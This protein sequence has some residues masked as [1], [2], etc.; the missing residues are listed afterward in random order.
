[1][2][3]PLAKVVE[4]GDDLFPR[5]LV[6][7]VDVL[8][9]T[10]VDGQATESGSNLL[11]IDGGRELTRLFC[12]ARQFVE[13]FE[14]SDKGDTIFTLSLFPQFFDQVSDQRVG[15]TVEQFIGVLLGGIGRVA[16]QP[17]ALGITVSPLDVVSSKLSLPVGQGSGLLWQGK[18]PIGFSV[19]FC[20]S[21]SKGSR[22]RIC[23]PSS[24]ASVA[25][26]S[27]NFLMKTT[28]ATHATHATPFPKNFFQKLFRTEKAIGADTHTFF[29]LHNMGLCGIT[30]LMNSDTTWDSPQ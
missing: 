6:K 13:A 28:L 4:S 17:S 2:G 8:L 24:V 1:M 18:P 26:C 7:L 3:V 21:Q 23:S 19:G 16:S 9:L 20:F 25:K 10:P 5:Q 30:Y 11:G 12:P 15:R 14:L 27:G 22:E 29:C